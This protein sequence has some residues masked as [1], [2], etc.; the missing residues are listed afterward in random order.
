MLIKRDT[1]KL[2]SK[3]TSFKT[4]LWLLF[5]GHGHRREILRNKYLTMYNQNCRE[6]LSLQSPQ[7]LRNQGVKKTE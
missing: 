4:L 2:D 3:K 1:S 7:K 5:K 6:G